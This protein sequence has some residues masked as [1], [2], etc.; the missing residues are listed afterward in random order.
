LSEAIWLGRAYLKKTIVTFVLLFVTL[1]LVLSSVFYFL[2]TVNPQYGLIAVGLYSLITSLYFIGYYYNKRAYVFYIT[3]RLIHIRK[4]WI[5]GNYE[6][7]ITLDQI[8]DVYF[9]QGII[10]R[11]FNC[12]NLMF[13][14]TAGLEI[15]Y[16]HAGAGVR[17]G[18]LVGGGVETATTKPMMFSGRG[19]TFWDILNPSFA[20]QTLIDKLADWRGVFQQQKMARA[21]ELS[22][23]LTTELA[24]L[25]EL[26]ETGA[27]KKRN[28]KRQRKNS[29]NKASWCVQFDFR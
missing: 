23:S 25:H 22:M 10:A 17:A 9:S 2:W 19:N 5:F 3:D 20:K 26:E 21:P 1:A 12:G 6:R 4:S 28:M 8:R 7:E 13:V 29:L 14:T 24:R 18:V 11:I 27:I 16:S 15:G